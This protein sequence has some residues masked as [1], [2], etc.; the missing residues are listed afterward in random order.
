MDK[1]LLKRIDRDPEVRQRGRSA[2]IRS[3]VELYLRTKRRREIDAEIERAYEGHA[4]QMLDEV[5]EL[6][7]AQE[8]PVD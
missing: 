3:A 1:E 2:F 5:A 7:G 6:V 8:W 4:K